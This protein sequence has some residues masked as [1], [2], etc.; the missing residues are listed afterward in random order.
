[1][2]V[3]DGF[4]MTCN[5][6]VNPVPASPAPP[7]PVI[8]PPVNPSNLPQS[9][10]SQFINPNP[11]GGALVPAAPNQPALPL[12]PARPPQS[13]HNQP[14]P[15]VQI[16]QQGMALRNWQGQKGGPPYFEGVVD[17]ID[18]PHTAHSQPALWKQMT[19]AMLLGKLSPMLGMGGYMMGKKDYHVWTCRLRLAPAYHAA[20]N[21]SP[22]A[23]IFVFHNQPQVGFQLGDTI[24]VWGKPD[25]GGNLI[26]QRAYVY[27][28]NTTVEVKK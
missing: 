20:N 11:T 28:T 1:M 9:G 10:I 6:A 14:P 26:M 21:G 25:N 16:P 18:G 3:I 27:D 17:N 15:V 19:A 5:R 22:S 4:C 23:I 13:I 8:T 12:P 24:A 2:S 7:G